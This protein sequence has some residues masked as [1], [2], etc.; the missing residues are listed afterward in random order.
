MAPRPLRLSESVITSAPVHSDPS[1]C[2]NAF[3]EVHRRPSAHREHDRS[4]GGG[5][6]CGD[7]GRNLTGTLLPPADFES[8]PS[9]DFATP[10]ALARRGNYGTVDSWRAP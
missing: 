10:A 2:A 6:A 1:W 5:K 3:S 7:G 4:G 8:A 9:S